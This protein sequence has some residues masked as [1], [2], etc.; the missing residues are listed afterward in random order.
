MENMLL[1]I[2][3]FGIMIMVAVQSAFHLKMHQNKVFHF[4]KN[5]F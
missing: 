4:F 2:G 1:P 5:H 3:V